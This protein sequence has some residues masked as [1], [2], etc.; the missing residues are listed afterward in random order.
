VQTAALRRIGEPGEMA[1]AVVY[2]ASAA[3]SFTSGQTL[4]LDGGGIA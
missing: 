4:I 1:G 2:F 3:S